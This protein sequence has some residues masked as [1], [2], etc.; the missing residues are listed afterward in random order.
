MTE[1]DYSFLMS[2][3]FLCSRPVRKTE[4]KASFRYLGVF[5]VHKLWYDNRDEM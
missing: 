5:K 2:C 4:K 1:N 3:A